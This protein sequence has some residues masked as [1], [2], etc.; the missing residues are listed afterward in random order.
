MVEGYP[1]DTK[2]DGEIISKAISQEIFNQK[3]SKISGQKIH[4]ILKHQK[5]KTNDCI[6]TWWINERSIAP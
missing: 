6:G 4:Q 2:T 5:K 3:Y 1:L